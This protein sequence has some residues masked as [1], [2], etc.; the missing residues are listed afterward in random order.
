M[1]QGL[2][3]HLAPTQITAL[4]AGTNAKGAVNDVSAQAL[5]ELGIDVSAHRP[6]QL[7][8]AMI[9]DADLVVVVGTQAHVD[10]VGDTPVEVW[11]TDEPSLRGIDGLERMR[12]IRDDIAGRVAALADRLT[13]QHPPV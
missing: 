13:R 12:L 3:R 7:T 8:A 1:A 2:M 5:A 11:D 9:E 6:T 10:P 4:S